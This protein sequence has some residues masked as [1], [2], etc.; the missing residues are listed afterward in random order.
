LGIAR[1]ISVLLVARFAGGH[2]LGLSTC[3]FDVAGDGRVDAR[4]VFASTEPLRAVRLD[5]DGDGLVTEDEVS[6]AAP[7][8]RAFVVRGVDVTA[9]GERCPATFQGATVRETD[10]LVLT[11]SF[12]CA[13]GGARIAATLYYLS[14]LG[15]DHRE[16]ARITA[17]DATEEAVLTRDRRQIALVVPGAASDALARKGKRSAA[18]AISAA[19]VLALGLGLRS[20]A[21]RRRAKSGRA[22]P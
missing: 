21:W 4:F 7:E 20:W 1:V 18:I 9:D 2:T 8:L 16:I 10:G 12:A 5:R 13:P 6:A 14:D 19:A 11:A 3:D 22:S 15:R 17:G